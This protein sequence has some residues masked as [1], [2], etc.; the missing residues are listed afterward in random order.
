MHE[1]KDPDE[2]K[3]IIKTNNQLF[4]VFQMIR[5]MIFGYFSLSNKSQDSL[6]LMKVCKTIKH[7]LY[8]PFINNSIFKL[9]EISGLNKRTRS[10]V[11]SIIV[12]RININIREMVPRISKVILNIN[13]QRNQLPEEICELIYDDDSFFIHGFLIYVGPFSSLKKLQHLRMPGYFNQKISNG[14]FPENLQEL[15]FREMFDQRIGPGILPQGLIKLSF[16]HNFNQI[17]EPRTLPTSLQELKF[18]EMFDQRIDPGTLSESLIKLLFGRGFNQIIELGTLPASLQELRF[19]K[20]FNQ[21]INPGVLPKG[22]IKLSLGHN[23]DQIIEPGTLPVSLIELDLGILFNQNIEPGVLPQSLRYL[24]LSEYFKKP[25][26]NGS[27]PANLLELYFGGTF[28]QPLEHGV[29][30]QSLTCLGFG[31]AFNQPLEQGVLPQTLKKLIFGVFNQPLGPNILPKLE[32]L[33][34]SLCYT[35]SLIGV[36]PQSLRSLEFN[37]M[38]EYYLGTGNY[39]TSQLKLIPGIIPH[40]VRKLS[41]L[42]YDFDQD[43]SLIIPD[44]L[45]ELEIHDKYL[46]KNKLTR[47]GTR[48]LPLSLRRLVIITICPSKIIS[49]DQMNFCQQDYPGT[50]DLTRPHGYYVWTYQEEG[51]EV[52]VKN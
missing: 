31:A 38:D 44:G 3:K 30:P 15:E 28:D 27:L 36:L 18:G 48:F 49:N 29:L 24:K 20:V 5:T 39:T 34:I 2:S 9:S 25:I 52:S 50:W 33:S 12:D 35:H 26:K 51:G 21:K 16:G 42:R 6:N 45:V 22:L 47:G 46:E 40:S 7:L 1:Q 8:E 4:T 19:G 10:M 14:F 17:I 13:I 32:Y 11:R 23:F 37:R 41:F 43:L